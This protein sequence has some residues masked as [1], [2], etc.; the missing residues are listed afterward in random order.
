MIELIQFPWSPYCLV[1]RRIL[2][3]SGVKFNIVNIPPSDR[4]LVWKLTKGRYYQVPL[5][6]D[7]GHAVFELD[8]NSQ[9][10]AKYLDTRLQLGL[11]PLEWEGVQKILWQYIDTD[12]EGLTFRLNDAYFREVV[13]KQ[14]QL[15]YLRHKERKFGRGCL[16]E[17]LK[18]RTRLAAELQ[19]T[20]V[21]FERMLCHREFLLGSRPLFVDFNL[22]GMLANLLFSGHN[23]LPVSLPAIK[24][25]Y[26]RMSRFQSSEVAREKLHTGY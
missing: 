24:K 6:T 2:E 15:A 7:K 18:N 14:E 4:S 13:P 1:Q 26:G 5:I 16:A 8:D 3:Y 25:W 23:R 21:P 20:L 22:W 10:I 17:W 11:F 9:V 12:V 19:H